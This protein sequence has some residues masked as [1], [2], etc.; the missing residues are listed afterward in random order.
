M[1]AKA[2]GPDLAQAVEV[3]GPRIGRLC[4][5]VTLGLVAPGCADKPSPP[6]T[7]GDKK[8]PD[9]KDKNKV[10]AEQRNAAL[11]SARVWSQPAV[12]IGSADFSVNTPGPGGFDANADVEC[13]FSLE[14]VS[15]MTPKFMCTLPNGDKVKVKYGEAI[16]NGE[17]PAEIT[18]TRLLTALGFPTDRMNRVH[19]IKCRGCPPLPQQALKCLEKR[20]SANVC[21]QGA[22]PDRVVTFQQALIERPLEGEKIEATDD[23]GWSWYELEKIDPKAGGSSRAEVDALRLIAVILVHWDNKGANQKL[24][25][26]AG[27]RQPDGSCPAPMAIIGDL[28][29]TFGP[30]RVDLPNWSRQAVWADPGSC[31]VSMKALPF[32]GATFPDQQIS[33]AGRQFALKLLR[34]L[35]AQQLNTLF[36]ASGLTAFPHIA[37]AAQAPQNWTAAFL[38]KVEQIASAGPCPN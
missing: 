27:K 15:G 28:G 35:T 21:L 17:V 38:A 19:S 14:P 3:R 2:D 16:P 30:N 1:R 7:A 32:D 8:K 6:E 29:A 31:K 26:P 37:A 9:D 4:L 5:V 25:C 23:Q 36:E 18:A 33:E 10:T 12:A 20:E 34:Q 11:A 13:T 24:L 22:A